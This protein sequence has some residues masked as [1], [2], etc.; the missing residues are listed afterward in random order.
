MNNFT[1]QVKNYSK[2]LQKFKNIFPKT[3]SR[4]L[5]QIQICLIILNCKNFQSQ[6]NLLIFYKQLSNQN[7]QQLNL[8]I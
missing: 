1:P 7:S 2:K 5:P 6:T 3:F 4:L 8:Q